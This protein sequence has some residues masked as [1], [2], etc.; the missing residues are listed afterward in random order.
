M[1]ELLQIM[2]EK[3]ENN[4]GSRI[5]VCQ[6]ATCIAAPAIIRRIRYPSR[7]G[8]ELMFQFPA[9]CRPTFD[10]RT[11]GRSGPPWAHRSIYSAAFVSFSI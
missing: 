3:K 9:L 1:E 6:H 7:P 5:I 4:A 10:V 11:D 8:P 2:G